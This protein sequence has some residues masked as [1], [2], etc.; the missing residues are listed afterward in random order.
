M[1]D[2]DHVRAQF[3]GL[4]TDWTLFDNAGGSVPCR[5]VIDRVTDHLRNRCVQL[6]GSYPMSAE[7]TEAVEDGRRAVA[8]LIG[9]E[10]D[11]VVLGSSSTMLARTLASALRPLLK[12]GDEVIVTGLDHET[13]VSGW[14]TLA[15]HGVVIKQWPFRPDGLRLELEDLEP[16]LTA[17]TRLVAFSHCSNIIGRI[18]DAAAIV[19]RVH[20][21]GAWTCVDGVAFG[22]HRR[23]DVKAL[24]TD[25]YFASLY[26]IYG[27]HVSFLYGKRERLLAAAGQN[28]LFFGEQDLP[29]KL[30]PGAP[31]HEL[32]ASLPGIIE[33][34]TGLDDGDS[35]RPL[36]AR[37]DRAFE[38]IAET[39]EAL[40]AP[41]LEFL[42]AHPS[43]R[44]IGSA[45]PT[46]AER[47][48]TISFT[49]EGR[50]AS[51]IIPPLDER[52][53]AVRWGHFYAY[54]LVRELGLLES[55]GVVRASMVHY[56]T[57]EEVVRLIEALD[58]VIG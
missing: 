34:L 27:P 35:D 32:S 29:D 14:R 54:R 46:S 21:A 15:E 6:G 1:L 39:E 37:L 24:D 4:E 52:K 36:T 19:R 7:A 10:A 5:Q 26:K 17:R 56:N 9:A 28:H 31:N 55:D 33:Y 42:D 50:K 16:L 11:E 51:E 12:P 41:L 2:L 18:H 40:C 20:E 45:D 25:F 38:R 30:E 43:V 13:N 58:E 8:A 57:P 23:I 3:P 49:V 48:P 47:A 53:L 44:L 22:P